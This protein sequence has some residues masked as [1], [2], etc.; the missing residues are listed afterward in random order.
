MTTATLLAQSR[1][2]TKR[3]RT[4]TRIRNLEAEFSALWALATRV[5]KALP[6]PVPQHYFAKPRRWRFDFAWLNSVYYAPLAVE[7]DGGTWNSGAHGRGSGIQRNNEKRN[8]AALLGW[9]IL[10]YTSTDLRRRPWGIV[11]EV[12]QALGLPALPTPPRG[13]R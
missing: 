13:A 11:A 3:R 7:I 10:V 8:A 5:E 9:R 6:Q 12:R 1:T 2:A 4:P